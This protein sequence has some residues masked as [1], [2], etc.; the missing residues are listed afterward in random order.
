M[1]RT[2]S[3]P[4]AAPPRRLWVAL[5]LAV[6]FAVATGA[7]GAG[8]G[9]FAV[10]EVIGGGGGAGQAGV[11]ALAGTVGQAVA[12]AGSARPVGLCS[13]F[14]CGMAAYETYLPLIRR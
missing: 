1:R 8:G 10:R 4:T 9:G 14:W 3:A 13:G 6:I 12:G 5:W 2:N 11:F 7:A